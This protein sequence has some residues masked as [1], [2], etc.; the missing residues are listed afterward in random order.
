MKE[1]KVLRGRLCLCFCASFNE[2]EFCLDITSHTLSEGLVRF[3]PR[4]VRSIMLRKTGRGLLLL[5]IESN[6]EIYRRV[7][8]EKLA[9]FVFLKISP[10]DLY[11][12][13]KRM[14]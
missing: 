11:A 8:V 12:T 6:K 13:G 1:G 2:I 7:M 9:G 10:F 3:V 4:I 5:N 14:K